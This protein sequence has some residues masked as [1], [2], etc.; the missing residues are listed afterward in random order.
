MDQGTGAGALG[1]R[2]DDCAGVDEEDG[3]CTFAGGGDGDD[4]TS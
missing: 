2:V 1:R 4:D 3:I